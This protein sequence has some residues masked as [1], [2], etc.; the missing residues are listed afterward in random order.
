MI[1]HIMNIRGKPMANL[2][3]HLPELRSKINELISEIHQVNCEI[4]QEENHRATLGQRKAIWNS[5][6][7]RAKLEARHG[8][9]LDVLELVVSERRI[10]NRKRTEA[11]EQ[12]A[13]RWKLQLLARKGT[14]PTSGTG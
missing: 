10:V 14:P 5:D 2:D 3:S 12:R 9:L 8:G 11:F 1:E 7:R 6:W 4:Q 13:K